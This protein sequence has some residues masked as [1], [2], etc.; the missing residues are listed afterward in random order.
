MIS[1]KSG[2]LVCSVCSTD[3]CDHLD[4]CVSSGKD[5]EFF[6]PG[7][8]FDVPIF[9][10]SDIYVQIELEKVSY[11]S[12]VASIVCRY[13]NEMSAVRKVSL[14]VWSEGEGMRVIRSIVFDFVRS[15]SDPRDFEKLP[16]GATLADLKTECPFS[17]HFSSLGQLSKIPAT[18]NEVWMYCWNVYWERCCTACFESTADAASSLGSISDLGAAPPRRSGATSPPRAPRRSTI[19]SDH[20]RRSPSSAPSVDFRT[21]K[22]ASGF[23]VQPE[24]DLP[25]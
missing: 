19:D 20:A 15:Q 17:G 9:P 14:G 24:G 5:A 10:T 11:S 13:T 16:D 3:W 6:H 23:A 18:R 25:F 4:K 8:H 21:V 2:R 1:V 22:P 12:S 7:V